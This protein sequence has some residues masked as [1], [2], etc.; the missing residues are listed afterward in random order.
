VI[1]GASFDTP[2][3]NRIFAEN[4]GFPFRLLSDV[5]RSVGALYETLRAPEEQF[6]EWAKRRTFV[7]D[8]EGVIRKVY[9]VKD[10][11]AHPA[12][13]LD[14]LRPLVAGA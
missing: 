14:D 3:E 11:M 2:E 8:P 12:E 6:N 5:D 13:L 10:A 9:A 4:N 1:L 7:I